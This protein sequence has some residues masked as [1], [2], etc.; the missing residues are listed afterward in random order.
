MPEK[1]QGSRG[2]RAGTISDSACGKQLAGVFCFVFNNSKSKAHNQFFFGKASLKS[3]IV[4][5]IKH[6]F[7]YCVLMYVYTP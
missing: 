7:Y 4:F 6:I 5:N 2:L 3:N 1:Q